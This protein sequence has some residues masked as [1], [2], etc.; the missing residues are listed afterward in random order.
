[1]DDDNIENDNDNME[2]IQIYNQNDDDSLDSGFDSYGI[3]KVQ[4]MN[5]YNNYK[6]LYIIL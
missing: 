2:D 5:K 1:M 3:Y 4:K 6:I